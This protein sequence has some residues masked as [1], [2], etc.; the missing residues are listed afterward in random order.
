MRI[1]WQKFK[2][3]K[4]IIIIVGFLL[5]VLLTP[6][7]I[8]AFGFGDL[9]NLLINGL[10]SLALRVLSGIFALAVGVFIAIV[11]YDFASFPGIAE[12][13]DTAWRV[14][15]DLGNMF[16]IIAL[17]VISFATMLKIE[18][19][20]WS[21]MMPK[22]LGAAIFVNFSKTISLIILDAGQVLMMTFVRAFE[23]IAVDNLTSGLMLDK[24]YSMGSGGVGDLLSTW[25]TQ[26][27]MI[28]MMVITVLVMGVILVLL[29]FRII[30]IWFFIAVSPI[31]YIGY[32]IPG[33]KKH[34]SNWWS[35]FV[36]TVFF[37]PALAFFL[38][39]SFL[40]MSQGLVPD[41]N[42][43]FTQIE[44][45][46]GGS[47]F[48]GEQYFNSEATT[49]GNIIKFGLAVALLVVGTGMAV[50]AADFGGG[51]AGQIFETGKSWFNRWR[52]RGG[53]I[54][55][56]PGA[57][58]LKEM[59]GIRHIGEARKGLV[60][61]WG[62]DEGKAGLLRSV[63][64]GG[65][66]AIESGQFKG[67]ESFL[68]R[69]VAKTTGFKPLEKIMVLSTKAGWEPIKQA[70]ELRDRDAKN[71]AASIL[72]GLPVKI[73]EPGKLVGSI[74]DVLVGA[75]E[76]EEKKNKELN[77]LQKIL[78]SEEELEQQG[79]SHYREKRKEYNTEM[80]QTAGDMAKWLEGALRAKGYISATTSSADRKELVAD[81]LK[82]GGI[83]EFTLDDFGKI[84]EPDEYN[85][86]QNK[87]KEIQENLN[88]LELEEE[89]MSK[90]D[91][92][93]EG[94][95]VVKEKIEK[96]KQAPKEVEE[97]LKNQSDLV[98][99][100]SGD[101]DKGGEG[102]GWDNGD[103]ESVKKKLSQ[104]NKRMKEQLDALKEIKEAEEK[105]ENT[106]GLRE[107]FKNLQENFK[108]FLTEKQ[109]SIIEDFDIDSVDI[110]GLEHA[111]QEVDKKVKEDYKKALENIAKK[112][113]IEQSVFAMGD[114]EELTD[115]LDRWQKLS[116]DKKGT[117]EKVDKLKKE[118]FSLERGRLSRDIKAEY[119]RKM[120]ETRMIEEEKKYLHTLDW[121][122]LVT[123]YQQAESEGNVNMA[124]AVMERLIEDGNINELVK[125]K[126]WSEGPENF[127]KLGDDFM[128]TFNLSQQ[129]A[130]GFMKEISETSEKLGHWVYAYLYKIE[131]GRYKKMTPK[132]QAIAAFPMME[133]RGINDIINN[134]RLALGWTDKE[135]ND[136][137]ITPHGLAWLEA[138]LDRLAWAVNRNYMRPELMRHIL[139]FARKPEG[140]HLQQA[141]KQ[142]GTSHISSYEGEDTFWDML[143]KRCL[144]QRPEDFESVINNAFRELPQKDSI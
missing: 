68:G 127:Q 35:M 13:V 57:K 33:L 70:R 41:N 47:G 39:F 44:Q 51:A 54:A 19:Y 125:S 83:D 72:G 84:Y 30:V 22:L 128:R 16:F 76:R 90:D 141:M 34:A 25:A 134:T 116:E 110:S 61:K 37:G 67:G 64:A 80:D 94:E 143:E 8:Y 65:R 130:Y 58:F 132:E 75:G 124:K 137:K 104:I 56:L 74:K 97:V 6:S 43:G 14:I 79:R 135:T 52:Q 139:D 114:E 18:T 38:W 96:I 113:K 27:L 123:Y 53:K 26:V 17:L 63:I 109:Q 91:Y 121:P 29:I 95:E 89:G 5:F 45:R 50:K 78:N 24:I 20:K 92:V 88:N 100:K 23:D 59:P 55:D 107:N 142:I 138:H 32:A 101:E 122:Q 15:R 69:L 99:D 111:Y 112:K 11:Q 119:F 7:T 82:N 1:P 140:R 40:F 10:L 108:E 115:L 46:V 105:G 120:H 81:V 102:E 49:P 31:A 9:A 118:I 2:K 87:R 117:K 42:D 136:A 66:G 85:R 144:V 106:D 103:D 4:K 77:E 93:Q 21:R 28:A 133:K 131:N 36:K 98:G 60:K 86:I 3:R 126:G 48:T 71:R 129:D 62:V 73:A 12:S